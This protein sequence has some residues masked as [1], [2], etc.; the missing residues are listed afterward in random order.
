[1][2]WVG[3]IQSAEGLK[4]ETEVSLRRKKLACRW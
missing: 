1:M 4:R 2:V 3:L